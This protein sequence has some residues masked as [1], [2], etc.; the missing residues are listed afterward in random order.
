MIRSVIKSLATK[1]VAN[2]PTHTRLI[3]LA[4]SSKWVINEEMRE[5]SRVA[6]SLGIRVKSSKW[7]GCSSQ[8][9]VFY[10]SHFFL[11]GDSWREYDHRIATAYFHGRPGSGNKEFDVVYKRL[12]DE[13]PRISRIQ[14]SHSRMKEIVLA[15]GIDKEKVFLIPIGINLDYFRP[16][17]GDVRMKIRRDL[18]VPESAFVVGSFQKDGAGWGEGTEPKLIKGPDILLGVIDVLKTRV[19]ELFVLLSGPARGFVK[20][21]LERM[22]VPF[23]HVYVESY[24]D[25]VQLYHAL[26][27]YIVS[28]R[29]EGGPKAV[30]ESMASGVPLVTT[31]VGQ[32]ADLVRHGENA[33]MVEVEDVEGLAHWTEWIISHRKGIDAV[34][35][36]ARKTAEANSYDAQ[37]PLW[38]KFFDGFVEMRQ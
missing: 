35:A 22:K 4:D 20:S 32:A 10:G 11:L 25:A 31:R 24:P 38:R 15:S 30:L 37:H 3:P 12:C 8:Q 6:R 13:H 14:V 16:V 33:W 34:L 9:C 19:P 18:G 17:A 2:W 5:V 27:V 26:D 21:G 23:R 1:T 29:E 36:S 7:L 28:S